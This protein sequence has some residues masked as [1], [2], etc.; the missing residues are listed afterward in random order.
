MNETVTSLISLLGK[1]HMDPSVKQALISLGMDL[2]KVRL[3]R[4]DVDMNMV[5]ENYGIEIEFADQNKYRTNGAFPEGAL[6]LGAIFFSPASQSSV[7]S[8][9]YGMH[10]D[11]TRSQVAT[12]LGNPAWSSPVAPIDRWR[13]DARDLTVRFDRATQKAQRFIFSLPK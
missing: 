9:P 11:M 4:G 5:A 6:V 2:K 3:K 8:L 7:G 13:Q 1:A 10:F 12:L